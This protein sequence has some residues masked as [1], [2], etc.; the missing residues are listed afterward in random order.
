MA[1]E[2]Q[3][4]PAV[5]YLISRAGARYLEEPNRFLWINGGEGEGAS[6]CGGYTA[7]LSVDCGCMENQAQE[8]S[9]EDQTSEEF[10]LGRARTVSQTVQCRRFAT[11]WLSDQCYKRISRHVIVYWQKIKEERSDVEFDG[12]HSGAKTLTSVSSFLST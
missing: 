9:R 5:F 2:V 10:V 1:V 12:F 6:L 4:E 7:V 3:V 8:V 11:T